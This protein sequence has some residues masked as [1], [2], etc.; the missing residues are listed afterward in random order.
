MCDH[1]KIR[2]KIFLHHFHEGRI[3][4]KYSRVYNNE[5][6]DDVIRLQA[7]CILKFKRALCNRDQRYVDLLE[8]CL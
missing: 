4:K 1:V 3:V 5:L 7:T 8:K 2:Y 6:Q